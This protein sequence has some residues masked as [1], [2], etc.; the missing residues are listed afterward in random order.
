M[1]LIDFL[2]VQIRLGKITLDDVPERYREEVEQKLG[3]EWKFAIRVK[4]TGEI[5]YSEPWLDE[6]RAVVEHDEK[7]LIIG[8]DGKVYSVDISGGDFF[9]LSFEDVSDKYEVVINAE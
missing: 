4:K 1:S 5:I 6:E 8:F 3:G 2:V 7:N 9:A